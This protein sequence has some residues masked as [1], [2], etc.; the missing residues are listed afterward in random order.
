MYPSV[1]ES[2]AQWSGKENTEYLKSQCA[3]AGARQLRG[4]RDRTEKRISGQE[5]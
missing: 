4:V 5:A 3:A 2:K 1:C